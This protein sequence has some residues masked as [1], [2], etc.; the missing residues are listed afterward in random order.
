LIITDNLLFG[1]QPT[2]VLRYL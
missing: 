1:I 2:G